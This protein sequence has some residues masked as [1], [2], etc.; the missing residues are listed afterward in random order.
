MTLA[1]IGITFGIEPANGHGD[2]LDEPAGSGIAWVRDFG[3]L[4]GFSW[5]SKTLCRI[6]CSASICSEIRAFAFG[7]ISTFLSAISRGGLMFM[8]IV[9][10]Q[11]IWLPL[12]GYSFEADPVLGRHSDAAA[13]RWDFCWP[14][15][16]RAILSDR[17]RFAFFYHRRH[18][19]RRRQLPVADLFCRSIFQLYRNSPPFCCSTGWRMG[20]F[21][22]PN[23]A[24]IMNSLPTG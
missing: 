12:H 18:A 17:F 15:R 20:A 1:M 9:W 3:L 11:G 14:A 6:R 10:L 5:L 7:T 13:D 4:A 21:S 2:G 23:R 24:A 19:R 22:S 8:L 16:S